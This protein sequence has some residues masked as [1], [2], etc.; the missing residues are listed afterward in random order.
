MCNAR[1]KALSREINGLS[2]TTQEIKDA[3]IGPGLKGGGL[4]Q[5]VADLRNEFKAS[6]KSKLSLRDK[7][8]I[9]I[10]I[11]SAVIPAIASI[12]IALVK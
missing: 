5:D 7:T 4:V 2:G 6:Q 1:Y 10:G 8:Y 9:T 12:Y 3:L 11:L